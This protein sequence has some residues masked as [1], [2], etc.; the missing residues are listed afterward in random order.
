MEE[1]FSSELAAEAEA[2]LDEAMKMLSDENPELWQQFETF[3]KSM[4]LDDVARGPAPPA[5][6]AAS[7]G[8]SSVDAGS[9]ATGGEGGAKSG[10][11]GLKQKLEDTMRR[12]QENASRV[13][14]NCAA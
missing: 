1:L 8:E 2:Q 3:A 14:V 4:G 10:G 6:G 7:K 12:M 5:S 11:D 13:G 9:G